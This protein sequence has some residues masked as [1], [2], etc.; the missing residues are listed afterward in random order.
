[1]EIYTPVQVYKPYQATEEDLT[2]YHTEDYVQFLHRVTPHNIQGFAKS[3]SVFNVGE[4]CP[5][6]DGIYDFCSKYTGATLQAATLLNNRSCDIAVNW[7][8]GRGVESSI[9][10]PPRGLSSLL[11]KNIKFGKIQDISWLSG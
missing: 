1:M 2:R 5:V 3:L 4:D 11:G 9:S 6:F 10:P 7:S 8:G